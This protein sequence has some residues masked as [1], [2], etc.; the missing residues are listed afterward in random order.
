MEDK[1]RRGRG[2]GEGRMR[3]EERGRRGIVGISELERRFD[4]GYKG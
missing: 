1:G 4:E 2:S 3:G